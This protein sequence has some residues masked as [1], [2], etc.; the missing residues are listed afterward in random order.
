MV[1]SNKLLLLFLIHGF[2]LLKM[3]DFLACF[4]MEISSSEMSAKL[5]AP[6]IGNAMSSGSTPFQQNVK[7]NIARGKSLQKSRTL[8]PKV[9]KKSK[10]SM[11]ILKSPQNLYIRKKSKKSREMPW[12]SKKSI[13]IL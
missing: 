9:H 12:I 11:G 2:P 3:S 6:G 7:T 8:W 4:V 1:T 10:K 5:E 13:K